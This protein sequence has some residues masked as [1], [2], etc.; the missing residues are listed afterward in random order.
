MQAG[1][2]PDKMRFTDAELKTIRGL[3]K[4]NEEGLQIMR[5]MFLPEYDHDAPLGQVVDM[6]TA[7]DLSKIPKEDREVAIEVRNK[8]IQHVES[9]LL[10]LNYIANMEEKTPDQL[11]AER[12]ANSTK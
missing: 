4:G 9:A 10:A 12:K 6:W 1:V 3:F 8:L 5:K 11:E 7:L 2:Q